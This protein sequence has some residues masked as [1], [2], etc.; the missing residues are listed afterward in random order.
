[1]GKYQNKG[2]M[3]PYT[4]L[5]LICLWMISM[6]IAVGIACSEACKYN[7]NVDEGSEYSSSVNE[8]CTNDDYGYSN[9]VKPEYGEEVTEYIETSFSLTDEERYTVEQVVMTECGYEP[10]EGIVAVVQC[11]YNTALHNGVSPAT[12]VRVP[13]QY[14]QMSEVIAN[15]NVKKAVSQVFDREEFYVSEPIMYFYAPKYSAGTWHENSPNL[16]YVCTI[17]GHKFFKLRG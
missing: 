8:H 17:G 1:M 2:N 10:Y 11:I 14:A 12:V 9:D 16:Q 4:A 3:S 6:T 5:F 13:G 15:D 7:V